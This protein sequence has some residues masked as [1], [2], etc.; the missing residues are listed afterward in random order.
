VI[1]EISG[2]MGGGAAGEEVTAKI[3]FCAKLQLKSRL[4]ATGATGRAAAIRE[5]IITL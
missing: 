5:R 4:G 3:Y 2:P 1:D